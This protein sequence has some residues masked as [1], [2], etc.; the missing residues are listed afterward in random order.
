MRFDRLSLESQQRVRQVAL[1]WQSLISHSDA[2]RL[3]LLI[4]R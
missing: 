2:L 4:R 3:D 1:D